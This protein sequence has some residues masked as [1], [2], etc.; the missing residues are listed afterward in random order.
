M[1]SAPRPSERSPAAAS[2]ARGSE[3]RPSTAQQPLSMVLCSVTRLEHGRCQEN[4]EFWVSEVFVSYIMILPVISKEKMVSQ[5]T[6]AKSW[7]GRRFSGTWI[8]SQKKTLGLR[9]FLFSDCCIRLMEEIPNNHL[10]CIKPVVNNGGFSIST[11][12]HRI[13]EPSTVCPMILFLGLSKF[14]ALCNGNFQ[15]SLKQAHA[16]IRVRRKLGGTEMLI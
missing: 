12:D 7:F 14:R 2:P 8:F 1:H 4:G 10:R 13:S 3:A 16:T 9:G 11:G 15:P 6:L 5:F